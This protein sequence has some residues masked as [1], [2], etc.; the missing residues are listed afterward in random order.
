MENNNSFQF[1][2]EWHRKRERERERIVRLL[3]QTE[4]QLSFCQAP[5]DWKI[6]RSWNF[7]CSS[8]ITEITRYTICATFIYICTHSWSQPV[9]N[10]LSPCRVWILFSTHFP[11]PLRSDSCKKFS[12]TFAPSKEKLPIVGLVSYP[13][14]ATYNARTLILLEYWPMSGLAWRDLLH[15]NV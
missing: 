13:R 3:W 4:M 6:L 2:M 11:W 7:K 10:K 15:R 1:E 5:V 12:V 14:Y 9:C 8:Y